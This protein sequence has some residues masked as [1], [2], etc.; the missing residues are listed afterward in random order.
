MNLRVLFLAQF[1]QGLDGETFEANGSDGFHSIGYRAD[2]FWKD[3]LDFLSDET[4]V[5]TWPLVDGR[6]VLILKRD[7]AQSQQGIESAFKVPHLLF[8]SLVGNRPPGA[9]TWL[10]GLALEEFEIEC[11]TRRERARPKHRVARR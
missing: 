1:A 3:L 7:A 8:E 4:V 11:S 10:V 2:P 9:A 6:V 5:P